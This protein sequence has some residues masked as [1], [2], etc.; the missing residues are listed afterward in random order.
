M[1]NETKPNES[2]EQKFD[3]Y[4]PKVNI[5]FPY[6]L[7]VISNIV[8]ILG[9][10]EDDNPTITYVQ[11]KDKNFKFTNS[12]NWIITLNTYELTNGPIEI[13]FY[14]VDSLKN[15]SPSKTFIYYVSNSLIFNVYPIEFTV[16]NRSIE[17]T[18]NI[19]KKDYSYL[20]I[21]TNSVLLFET[22]NTSN[23]T[24]TLES[25]YFIE[26]ETNVIDFVLVDLNNYVTN[27]RFVKFDFSAPYLEILLSSNSYIW[28]NYSIPIYILD[29][30]NTILYLDYSIGSNYFHVSNNTTNVINFNTFL[31]TNGNVTLKFWAKDVA[32]NSSSIYEIPTTVANYFHEE[33][34]RISSKTYY[35]INSEVF[36]DKTV[37]FFTDS[38]FSSIFVSKE[39]KSFSKETVK[40]NYLNILPTG[41]MKSIVNK[42]NVILSYIRNDE[43]L[44]IRTNSDL[45]LTNFY[46]LTSI[47]NIFDFDLTSIND[48][49][50]VIRTT[51]NGF[52]IV[53]DIS[54]LTT[55]FFTNLSENFSIVS[56]KYPKNF[57]YSL[58]NSDKLLLFTNNN[59]MFFTNISGINKADIVSLS[60]GL[61]YLGI[62]KSN[63][64]DILVFENTLITNYS[65]YTTSNLY[66]YHIVGKRKANNS[67][68]VITE[69]DEYG[70]S[71]IRIL[72]I[73][74]LGV[75][76]EQKLN[77]T[78][79]IQDPS[80]FRELDT[81]LKNSNVTIFTSK[82]ENNIGSI[83]IFNGL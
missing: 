64:I 2:N 9:T 71:Q 83:L 43:R 8:T 5:V 82:Y 68:W 45:S 33:K 50:W 46:Q 74:E 40:Q 61:I 31:V 32:G 78:F 63:S 54:N 36:L 19:N 17:F 65:F 76:R 38:G 34:N 6:N 77:V 48:T 30:N 24:L 20:R 52:L 13:L 26:N 11:I 7:S 22:N 67:F 15:I 53:T 39:E 75:I 14:A 57:I 29:S 80:G 1:F 47:N 28:G 12:N 42:S 23:L 25:N 44:I 10:T 72:E 59:L 81:I 35:F 51:T 16:T 69:G 66:I 79:K 49:V 62:V 21:Y 70:N 18:I 37:L 56:E 41:K 3:I 73:S 27:T 58:Y 60:N 4:P 55:N